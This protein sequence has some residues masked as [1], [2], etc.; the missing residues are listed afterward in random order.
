MS[1]SNG[2]LIIDSTINDKDFNKK[3]AIMETKAKSFCTQVK[4]FLDTIDVTNVSQRFDTLGGAIS[5]AMK[6]SDTVNDFTRVMSVMTGSADEAKTALTNL[7]SI[8]EGTAFGFD[9]AAE[10]TQKLVISGMD[11][12]KA[13]DQIKTWGD[14]VAFYGD[15]SDASLRSVI[16]TI[17]QMSNDGNVH[18]SQMNRL[19]DA[20]IPATAIY[21]DAV[22]MSVEEVQAALSNGSINAQDFMKVITEAMQNGT[23]QFA[24]IDGA[25][26]NTDTS[27]S[28]FFS[29]MK[30]GVSAIEEGLTIGGKVSEAF[31]S[32]QKAK[33]AVTAF[34]EGLSAAKDANEAF[35][36]SISL[37][38]I[39]VGLFT[40]QI[41]LAQAA[42]LVWAKA[43]EVLNVVMNASTIGL[44]VLAITALVAGFIYLWNTS[45]SFREFWIELWNNVVEICGNVIN[46]IVTFFT[47]TIPQAW[48]N[49]ITGLS[50]LT[51]SIKQFFSDAW[52]GVIS[53][54]TETIPAW[55]QAVIDWFNQLPYNIGVFVGTILAYFANWGIM[56]LKF[57]TE[58]IPAFIN[59][60]IAWFA[61]LPGNI[62]TWLCNV[63]SN[64]IN[65]GVNLFN[66]GKD[67][68]GKLLTSI[69]D[70]VNS[71]PGKMLDIGKNIVE[72]IWNGISN[73]AGWIKDKIG[74]FCNG[75]VKGF[76]SFFGIKSPSRLMRDAIGKFLPP[77][78]AIGFEMAMPDAVGDMKRESDAMVN[79]LQKQIDV[80][81]GDLSAGVLLEKS[82]HVAQQASIIN[83]FPKSFTLSG[84]RKQPVYLV[85]DNGAELAHAL[86][87]PLNKQLAFVGG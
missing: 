83:Q 23:K 46:A 30:T 8:T 59:K 9:T 38:E 41:G 45:A 27:W 86:V 13:T 39:A 81:T 43:Q 67:A 75:V 3:L 55:I 80:S 31:G 72:G 24:A 36:G 32:F 52:N 57:V 12:N 34:Q 1:N 82:A 70:I 74:D 69:L 53:F 17:A 58:D 29:N 60:V 47:V 78:I 20:G 79:D 68:A 56:L 19:F 2:T 35:H 87:E 18:M 49:F 21:A 65:W 50:N 25:A 10:S 6:H 64:I 54:F 77:G 48:N 76:K 61:S 66:A 42:T 15:G 85:L 7:K 63:V 5:N 28:T 84:D 62:W 73:A 26:K 51:E 33:K 14:A 44:I 71:I 40:G 37:G 22:G 16:D 4:G 11:I